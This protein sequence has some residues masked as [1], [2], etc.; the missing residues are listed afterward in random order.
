MSR[1]PPF[2]TASC[3]ESRVGSEPFFRNFLLIHGFRTLS[4]RLPFGSFGSLRL[5]P[6]D[7]LSLRLL[8]LCPFG[9]ERCR[10]LPRQKNPQLGGGPAERL[11]Q[12]IPGS[13]LRRLARGLKVLAVRDKNR[14]AAQ[15]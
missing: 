15:P 11:A 9:S 2:R 1:D 4:V 6:F 12:L 7:S 10:A 8:R 13:R 14:R 3:G 5:Y